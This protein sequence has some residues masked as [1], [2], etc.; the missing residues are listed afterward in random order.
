MFEL[1]PALGPWCVLICWPPRCFVGFVVSTSRTDHLMCAETLS[2]SA[3]YKLFNKCS[4]LGGGHWQ[5]SVPL[6]I[7]MTFYND[8]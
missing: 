4:E 2:C 7:S 1:L 8:R 5:P 3:I 6:E